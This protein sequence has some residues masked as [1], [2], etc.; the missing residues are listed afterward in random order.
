MLDFAQD[1]ETDVPDWLHSGVPLVYGS[2]TAVE[3]SRLCGVA[4]GARWDP[5]SHRNYKSLE[6]ASE[7]VKPENERLLSKCHVRT[8]HS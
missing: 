3:A 5:S 2:S 1:P 7:R 8:W 4:Y 6:E